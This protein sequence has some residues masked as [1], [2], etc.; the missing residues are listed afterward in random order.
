M[1]ECI[2]GR[3][4]GQA[5]LERDVGLYCGFSYMYVVSRITMHLPLNFVV[6]EMGVEE[7]CHRLQATLQ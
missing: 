5:V 7:N 2:D 1:A 3:L 6:A 4:D